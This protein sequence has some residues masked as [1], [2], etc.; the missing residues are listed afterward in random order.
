[1][2]MRMVAHGMNR[3]ATMLLNLELCVDLDI[4]P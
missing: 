4:C 2:L 1:L 3:L